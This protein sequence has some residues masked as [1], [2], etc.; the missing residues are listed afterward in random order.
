MPSPSA[1]LRTLTTSMSG[2]RGGR[3]RGR[4]TGAA[5]G[6]TR[7]AGRSVGL[8]RRVSPAELRRLY[9]Q[10]RLV[11]AE[12]GERVGVSGRTVRAW[13]QQLGIPLRPRPE[14]RRRHLPPTP[15]QLRRRYLAD[16]LTTA[17]L[18]AHYS[19]SV[20]TVRRW[21]DDAGIRRRLPRRPSLA[22][23]REE[24]HRLYQAEGLSTTQIGERYGVSQSTAHNWLRAARISLRPQGRP[25][26]AGTPR[27]P[28]DRS[29]SSPRH[30][31][32]ARR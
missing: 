30:A 29:G 25:T 8:T 15:A 24:L 23:S 31:S 18:A 4:P 10:Q 22:P 16:G 14:R 5:G 7:P 27:P 20:S 1:A 12:I 21:L 17:Q 28:S 13:L 3:R 2:D 11:P 9:Q 6:T 19:V 32:S 26:R